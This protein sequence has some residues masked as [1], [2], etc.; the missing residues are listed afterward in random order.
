ML[1]DI[2]DN[3][4][5]TIRLLLVILKNE[6][7]TQKEIFEIAGLATRFM[8]AKKALDILIE[9]NLV[10]FNIETNRY[11]VK[12]IYLT[13]KGKKIAKALEQIFD[14]ANFNID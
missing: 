8:A 2:L 4:K 12:K 10:V 11:R 3:V 7:K 1:L 14:Q 9:N 5:Y 13:E 6:G